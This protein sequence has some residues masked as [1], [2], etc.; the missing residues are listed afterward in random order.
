MTEILNWWRGLTPR[1]RGILTVVVPTA[2]YVLAGVATGPHG[3][4]RDH[5]PFGIVALGVVQG[6]VIALGAMG[7]ILIYRANRFINFAHGALGSMVGVLAIGM[8]LQHGVS[9]W[10]ALPGAVI[11]GAIAGAAIEFLV[12]RRFQNATRLVVT[13][14]SIGL[15]QLLGG[16][17]L[18]GSQKIGFVSLTGGFN[19]PLHMSFQFDVHRFQGD[20]IL[21]VAIVPV[22]ILALTWFLL[23]THSGIGVRAAAENQ[24]RALLL[25]I[26]VRR[27]STYV[28]LIAGGL[29]AL[30]YMLQAPFSGVKPG[31]ASNGPT[32]LLPLLAAAVVARMESL[33][34]AFA[35][36]VGLGIM[37]NIVRWD[38][39]SK[40]SMV[41]VCYLIVIVA[42]LLL[43]RGK[44]SRGQESG[45]SS[46][47]AIGA[48]KPIPRELRS[49]P[50]VRIGK[51]AI[52]S[53]I[54]LAFIYLPRG[55]SPSNQLLAGF[56][57]VWAL[58]GV[59][60]V[61]LTGWGGHISLGQFGIAGVGGMVAANMIANNNVDFFF[62]ILAAAG[63]GALIALLVGL[64]ALRITGL[65]LAVTTLAFAIALDSF[66][67]N[68]N[69]FPQF[70]KSKVSRGVLW[71]RFNMNDNYVMYLVCL[72]F[73]A[74][75]ILLSL[76]VR[77]ARNGRVLIA[78]RDNQRAAEAASVPTT[79]VKLSGFLLAGAIAGVAGALDVLLIQGLSVGTFNP[80]DSITVF[81]TAVI[82]GLG[83]I[84]GA[85]IGVLLFKYLETLTF[86][87]DLRLALNGLG[88]LVVL[89]LL[90]GGLGQLVFNVRDRILRRIAARR[91]ILVPSLLA[92]KREADGEDKPDDEVDLLRGALAD[93]PAS[94]PAPPEPELETVGASQ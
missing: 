60:L 53:V 13:V 76:G 33:P 17:E 83:S 56:A 2:L 30:T 7:I 93:A 15:A 92:D 39:Q 67:L 82:G 61:I 69:T 1:R 59:S 35:A 46:W 20:E 8:V 27:L 37:E 78:T 21:I 31:V 80:L 91:G 48:I 26:P 4:V 88:L 18:F 77:K 3:W 81:S 11:A 49:L 66:F 16:L 73:L 50:E 79:Q 22:V 40:P 63:A 54:A 6:T 86:L 25:G 9:Y 32:V 62:V 58:I 90:P 74:V 89:Y 38:N 14:A 71:E 5:A 10:V 41:D 36:G 84:T 75:A 47:S 29:A 87:G 64:P 42:A 72:G 45:G 85:L 23:K 94:E 55:W 12:I 68:Q 57:I 24:D 70:I 34:T 43:Q 28:W 19:A 44:L 65:F 51:F 52:L